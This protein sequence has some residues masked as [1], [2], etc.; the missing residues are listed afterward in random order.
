MPLPGIN[1][2]FPVRLF[3]FQDILGSFKAWRQQN[4]PGDSKLGLITNE[5]QA[6]TDNGWQMLTMD[7]Y[8]MSD[9][10]VLVVMDTYS[11]SDLVVLVVEIIGSPFCPEAFSCV[12]QPRVLVSVFCFY[13][14]HISGKHRETSLIVFWSFACF[15]NIA[16][17]QTQTVKIRQQV[18]TLPS[19]WAPIK[20]TVSLGSNPNSVKPKSSN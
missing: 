18:M 5:E 13:L 20:A 9:L 1:V 8:I 16:F 6:T 17:Y 7:I 10:V 11:M 15:A 2:I 19:V 4:K 3:S 12:F 14:T